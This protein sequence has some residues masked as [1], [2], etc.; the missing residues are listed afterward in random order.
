LNTFS[1]ILSIIAL[2]SLGGLEVV[3][4]KEVE[5]ESRAVDGLVIRRDTVEQSHIHEIA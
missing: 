3:F 4:N 5:Q 2:D 1:I